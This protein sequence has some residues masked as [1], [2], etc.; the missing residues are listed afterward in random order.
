MKLAL[1][2]GVNSGNSIKDRLKAIRDNLD[3]DVYDNIPRFIDMALK[4]GTLYDRI[5]VISTLLQDAS[6]ENNLYNYWSNTSKETEV[7]LLCRKNA[8]RDLALRFMTTFK[9]P[10]AAAMLVES[11]TVQIISEAVIL[12]PT[13]ITSKY[14][15][16]DF[17]NVEVDTDEVV[18]EQ[19]KPEPKPVQ[20]AQQS[21]QAQKPAEKKEKKGLFAGLFGGKK[22]KEDKNK[23]AQQTQQQMNTQPQEQQI[24][25]T[26]PV[27]QPMQ[28]PMQEVPAQQ[29]QNPVQAE[30]TQFNNQD[31]F[32]EAN[33]T[34]L[35]N[36]NEFTE[37]QPNM[38]FDNQ[39]FDSNE[40]TIQSS[41]EDFSFGDS[42]QATTPVQNDFNQFDSDSSSDFD[43]GTQP[44][45][46]TEQSNQSFDE[47][48]DINFETQ[49]SQQPISSNDVFGDMPTQDT[50]NNQL[51][52]AEQ[53]DDINIDFG[54]METNLP[55]QESVSNVGD[56][57]DD[58]L[59]GLDI[60]GSEDAY[61]QANEQPKVIVKTE[62]VTKEVIRT[63]GSK[64][65]ALENVL[66]GKSKKTVIVTGDRATG[67]TTAALTIAREL[68][69]KI[70]VLYFDC[71]IETHGL[72][73][74]LNYETILNYE[75]S[76]LEGIRRCKSS[77]AF[78]SCVISYDDNF[79]ILTSDYTCDAKDE[80]IETAQS[81]VAEMSGNY[82]VVVVDCPI[83]KL[84]LIPD[85]IL[86]GSTVMCVEASKRG[87]MNMLCKLESSSLA[88]R[89]KRNI[90][91]RGT[92]FVTKIP[93]GLDIKK[94]IKYI[95]SM[96]QSDSCDWLSM[97]YELFNGRLDSKLLN[98]IL[99][100]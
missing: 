81:I 35:N 82:G 43:F 75:R 64:N 5:L 31:D 88:L 34:Q 45:M 86:T 3:I 90:V 71:D 9:T 59:G 25:N 12:R 84:H 92:M 63:V 23:Q 39:Q 17:M 1:V 2:L 83:D 37:T 77:Q 15:I 93:K 73:S 62:V 36:Q 44:A 29:M 79:D 47:N 97:Q 13:E 87:Y 65:T 8:D 80:D 70:P 4:R 56:T 96:Y 7:I 51:D 18:V 30:P 27:V 46:N 19:P 68:A 57:I 54:N 55:E 20:Q 6:L 76:H 40:Q 26:Q 48:T 94:L 10:V 95:S 50:S 85:L 89:Y 28:A 38:N 72:L 41:S 74:Y 60:A 99:D 21:A 52:M 67:V 32:I 61:R 69:K 58:D 66:C 33:S 24:Q 49:S 14:G 98:T 11:T 91:S 78:L 22:N 42:G 53:S 100:V 16:Q